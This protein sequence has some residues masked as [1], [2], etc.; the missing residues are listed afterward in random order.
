M[1]MDC[2]VWMH[3]QNEIQTRAA[4]PNESMISKA[5]NP[6]FCVPRSVCAPAP[7]AGSVGGGGRQQLGSTAASSLKIAGGRDVHVNSMRRL[8]DA[9]A[10]RTLNR[11][12]RTAIRL[13]DR[14]RCSINKHICVGPPPDLLYR[15]TP[16]HQHR[17]R[18]TRKRGSTS[19]PPHGRRPAAA[20][21]Q[22]ATTRGR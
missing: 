16:T 11:S 6:F 2:L 18:A 9:R 17:D 7:Q 14:G 10:R 19:T 13:M 12:M 5:R 1:W 15:H 8:R 22:A 21:A 3:K 4:P 20:R